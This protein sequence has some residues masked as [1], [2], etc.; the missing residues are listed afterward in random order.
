MGIVFYREHQ[1]YNPRIRTGKEIAQAR[2]DASIRRA[3]QRVLAAIEECFP[4]EI[5][6]HLMAT[7]ESLSYEF[8]LEGQFPTNLKRLGDR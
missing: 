2:A 3:Q 6:E 8:D 1:K 7:E 4:K 5:F